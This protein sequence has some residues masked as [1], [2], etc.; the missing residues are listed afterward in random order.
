MYIRF[1]GLHNIHNIFNKMVRDR[2]NNNKITQNTV[3]SY[4]IRYKVS[5]TTKNILFKHISTM[6]FMAQ[7]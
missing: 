7:K 6:F 3:Y 2:K 5:I 1:F 4:N